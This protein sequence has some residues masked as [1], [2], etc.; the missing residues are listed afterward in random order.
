MESGG[1]QATPKINY[2]KGVPEAFWKFTEAFS[3]NP[4]KPSHNSPL[5]HKQD[6]LL[7]PAIPHSNQ[8][9]LDH[10]I[11]LAGQTPTF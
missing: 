1:Q 5:N 3:C 7:P 9:D 4:T 2:D 8:T 10:T 11:S 6:F